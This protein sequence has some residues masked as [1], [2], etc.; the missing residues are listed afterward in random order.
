MNTPSAPSFQMP[1]TGTDAAA[2]TC[3]MSSRPWARTADAPPIST[4]AATCAMVRGSRI[5][6]PG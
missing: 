4:A 2:L 6:S 5:G 3:R 1:I